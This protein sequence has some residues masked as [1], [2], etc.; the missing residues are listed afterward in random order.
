MF[1]IFRSEINDSAS[2]NPDIK[3]RLNTWFWVMSWFSGKKIEDLIKLFPNVTIIGK[4]TIFS[5]GA[6]NCR[7]FTYIQY[8]E[9]RLFILGILVKK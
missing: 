2:Q 9:Q 6:E 8:D 4:C 3:S 7:V 1:I 5:L